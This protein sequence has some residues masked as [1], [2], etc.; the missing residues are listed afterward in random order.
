MNKKIL[1][2]EILSFFLQNGNKQIHGREIAR[3]LKANQKTVQNKL[4]KLVKNKILEKKIEGKNHSYGINKDNPLLNY[5]LQQTELNKTIS[6][7][8]KHFEIK[9]MINEI[10]I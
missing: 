6:F 8:N 10:K 3:K 7:L 2:E 9:L 1:N 4:N 5:Y